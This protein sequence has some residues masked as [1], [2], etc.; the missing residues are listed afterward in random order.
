MMTE[1]SRFL[2]CKNI[3]K[4]VIT[5]LAV[6]IAFTI[7]LWNWNN[8]LKHKKQRDFLKKKKLCLLKQ[9]D[10]LAYKNWCNE[11]LEDLL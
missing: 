4:I 7:G 5:L 6:F 11:P 1:R 9:G 3:K 8:I 10:T 2:Y